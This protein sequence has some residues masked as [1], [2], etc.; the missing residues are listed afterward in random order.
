MTALEPLEAVRAIAHQ[1]V[2]QAF[3]DGLKQLS[4]GERASLAAALAPARPAPAARSWEEQEFAYGALHA[5]MRSKI[6]VV[7]AATALRPAYSSEDPA[8]VERWVEQELEKRRRYKIAM[9]D[10]VAK[11]AERRG[12]DPVRAVKEFLYMWSRRFPSAKPMVV[13]A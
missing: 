1:A 12:L 4:A 13:P 8:E 7:A 2:R 5:A 9:A 6:M 10:E 3:S 11:D